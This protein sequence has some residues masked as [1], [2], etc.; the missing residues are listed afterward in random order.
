MIGFAALALAL[1][2]ATLALLTRALWRQARP[3]DVDGD[4]DAKQREAIDA[5]RRRMVELD[6]AHSAGA[7]TDADHAQARE[8]LEKSTTA[9][10]W[11]GP[12]VLLAG[13]LLILA[14]VLRR[15][16]RLGPEAFEPDD[17]SDPDRLE[18]LPA[19][20]KP[21]TPV[22]ARKGASA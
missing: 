3:D 10:L 15:R 9:L 6:A 4:A 16:A 19:R 1:T 17:E 20:P 22:D 11:V 18:P 12:G 7:V 13:G 8:A 21:A 5:L 2:L 14:G